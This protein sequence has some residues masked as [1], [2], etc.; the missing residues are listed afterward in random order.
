MTE[1]RVGRIDFD[2][3]NRAALV[4]LPS[5]LR[6]WLPDARLVGEELVALNPRRA[7]RKAG[8][9][10]TNIR[11]GMWADFAT[12]HRGNDPVSLVAYLEGCSQ[13]EAARCL[14]EALGIP[15]EG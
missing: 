11:T 12:T 2:K 15:A 13:V 4:D 6:R 10:K 7:D 5:I 8:S 14:A 9:F 3:I 1:N